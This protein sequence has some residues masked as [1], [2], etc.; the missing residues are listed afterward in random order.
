MKTLT[1]G[2]IPENWTGNKDGDARVDIGDTE[3]S[4]TTEVIFTIEA[5]E[6]SYNNSV[7]DYNKAEKATYPELNALVEN[8]KASNNWEALTSKSLATAFKTINGNYTPKNSDKVV[9]FMG[10][11]GPEII[12]ADTYKGCFYIHCYDEDEESDITVIFS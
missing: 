7:I 6:F 11:D 1:L 4:N 10:T 5:D 9:R 3:F 12:E 2:F 8:L